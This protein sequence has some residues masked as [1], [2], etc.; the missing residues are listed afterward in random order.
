MTPTARSRWSTVFLGGSRPEVRVFVTGF[1]DRATQG[2]WGR[3][4]EEKDVAEWFEG[5]DILEPGLVEVSTWR[6]DTDV[7]P[8]QLT[9][10]WVEFG[11]VGL[12]R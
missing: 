10:E 6:P 8:R 12:L 3:V 1:M 7:A 5:L 2:H 11:G 4:R 9:H